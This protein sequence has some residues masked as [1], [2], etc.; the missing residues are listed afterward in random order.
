MKLV[1]ILAASAV[2]AG[3]LGVAGAATADAA[4]RLSPVGSVAQPDGRWSVAPVT[5]WHPSP[6]RIH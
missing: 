6:W 4:P 1:R 5:N 2:L 3:A